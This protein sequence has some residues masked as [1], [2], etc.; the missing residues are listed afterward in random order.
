MVR[1]RAALFSTVLGCAMAAAAAAQT[2]VVDAAPG[3]AANSFSPVRAMGAAVDRLNLGVAEKE[4]TGPMLQVILDSGWQSI[5]YRQ[6]TELHSEAWHWNPEG[7]WS[8]PAGKGYFTGNATPTQPI[9]HSFGYALP[10]RGT[11]RSAR[12]GM[13][14]FSRLT[15]GNPDSYWKSN[16]YLTR[17]FT[18]D[19][20]SQHPQWVLVD[21]GSMQPVNAIRIAWAQPYATRYHV[22][23]WTGGEQNPRR[24]TAGLW[25]TFPAGSVY[26]GRGGTVTL[27]LTRFPVTARYIRVWMTGSSNTCDTHGSGDRRNCVGFAIAELYIGTVAANGEFQDLVRHVAGSGQTSTI[28]SSVDPWHESSDINEKAGEQ[29][30]FDFFFH[31]GVTRGLPAMVPVAMLYGTPE[32]AAAEIAYLE[33]RNYPISYVELG[34][35]PDGQR[36][37]PEDYA[38]LYV[39]WAAAIYKVDPKLKLGGPVFEGVNEDIKVWPDA[40]GRVSWFGRFLDYLKA[41]GRIS[42]LAFMSFE[43]YPYTPC[44]SK[45]EDLY[46]EPELIAHI[47]DVWKDDGLPAGVPMMMTEGNVSSRGGVTA[48]DMMGGLWLADYTGAFFTAGGTASYYFHYV[49]NPLGAGCGDNG[50]GALTFLNMDRDYKM[51]GHLSQYF[52]SQV[53]SREWVQPVD[54]EHRIFRVSSDVRDDAG[55]VLVTAYAV[56]RPDGDWSL[57][58]INKDHDHPHTVRVAFDS[59]GNRQF[60]SGP[61]RL[62]SYGA[63]QFQ[64]HYAGADSYADPDL[65]PASSN[66]IANA[67]TTYTLPKASITVIRG[68]VGAP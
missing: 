41:H 19:D 31:S 61:M 14:Y 10:H 62:V 29:I 63:A 59:A 50:G 33:T 51:R 60:F 49:S 26:D 54:A 67:E 57:M 47:M 23:F 55:H 30:G 22:Q 3:H 43:H 6:N 46:R 65:P 34:E 44:Q 40:D 13:T 15:D 68:R 18:G 11:T 37:L 66:I 8:D 42:D 52:A 48:V 21:L 35:E 17:A 2:L 20:D 28:C 1:E 24:A 39:Q 9:Q 36:M 53:I 7:A 56:L 5:T 25:Q 58:A 4:L 27:T 38:A 45:W 64:W 32:D 16:P 12:G